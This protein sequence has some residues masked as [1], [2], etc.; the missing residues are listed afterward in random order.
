MIKYVLRILGESC[1]GQ[2]WKSKAINI[3]D[4]KG[5]SIVAV[6]TLKENA[7]E[8]ERIDLAQKLK[9]MKTLEPH[10]N[11]VRLI[12]CCTE[13]EQML[14]ILEYLSGGKPQSFLHEGATSL[15]GLI[16]K[17]TT[18][19]NIN[20]TIIGYIPQGLKKLSLTHCSLTSKGIS[21]L[22]H[23]FNLN[24]TITTSLNYLN[25]SDNNIKDDI[26]NLCNYLRQPNTFTYLD[27]GGVNATLELIFNALQNE[28]LKN[29]LLCLACNENTNEL[30]LDMSGNN[31][32]SMGAHILESC[33][34]GVRSLSSLD[35]SESN[36]VVDIGKVI[37]A[38]GE[39]KSIKHL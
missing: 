25:I 6:K 39:N 34:H 14:V 32:G 10:P 35:I 24:R 2:V 16:A 1:F 22:S 37:T 33:I 23:V 19:C 13:R 11:V 18:G 27:I 12:G 28:G 17:L 21:Q 29:L 3:N 8:R 38:I 15:C 26:N 4:K 20:G 31:L 36:M 5:T 7:T 9:V 30:E